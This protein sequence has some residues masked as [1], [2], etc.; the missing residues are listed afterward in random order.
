[1]KLCEAIT[2]AV[3]IKLAD[4]KEYEISP[5]TLFD[6]A[7]ME[8]WL[9]DLPLARLK[10]RFE[11]FSSVLDDK[12][13]EKMITD[14]ILEGQ[15]HGLSSAKLN[16]EL[17]SVEGVA[18][19]LFLSLRHKHSELKF[20][21]LEKLVTVENLADIKMLLDEASGLREKKNQ[22]VVSNEEKEKK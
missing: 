2:R 12:T 14:A 10:R 19:F 15:K 3:K 16:E 1:M 21:D 6:L 11:K 18:M 5:I 22:Q 8:K 13:K 9:E 4:G 17:E 20:E 7:E